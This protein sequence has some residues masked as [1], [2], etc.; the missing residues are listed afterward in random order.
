[1]TASTG[2]GNKGCVCIVVSQQLLLA[3][4]RHCELENGDTG[5]QLKYGGACVSPN[6]GS[7]A[8]LQHEMIH[9]PACFN[10]SVN[11]DVVPPYCFRPWC[12]VDAEVCMRD[13]LERVFRSSYFDLDS[14]VD[15]HFSYS[16][17]NSTAA[18]WL[19]AQEM[20]MIPKIIDGENLVASIA[21]FSFP[22][23][24]RIFSTWGGF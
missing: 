6:Y 19:E 13:S 5:V 17:C 15:I 23:K 4:E 10:V 22:S 8:C 11:Q 7:S 2:T 20:A 18:D 16:T 24:F 9:D 3:P 12:Y 14:G 1:M 21:G